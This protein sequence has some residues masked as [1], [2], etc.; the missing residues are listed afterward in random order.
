MRRRDCFVKRPSKSNTR[1]R[2]VAL[3]STA[4]CAISMVAPSIAAAQDDVVENENL[5]LI[6]VTARNREES[7]QDV[8]L[9]ITAFS[10]EAFTRRVIESLDDV[11]RLTAGLSFEDFT[12]GFAS[13]I[14][15]GQSQTRLTALEQNVSSFLDGVYLPRSWGIDLGT[16]N[17]T[18]IEVVKGPQSARYGRNAFSGA[19]N[20]VPYKAT[21]SDK[22]ISAQL[23]GTI[24]SD[25]RYDAGVRANIVLTP[26]LAVAGSYDYSTFDGTFGLSL[27][28]I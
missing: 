25:E 3:L 20:Y 22:P 16:A 28:H 6:I 23:T 26:R 11:A 15:R 5:D 4:F 27:I 17:L 1:I 12:G 2:N 21:L 24:G 14:I 19:I 8:P 10:E 9:A 7:I 13:P 18:R